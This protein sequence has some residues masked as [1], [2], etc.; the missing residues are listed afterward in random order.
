[1]ESSRLIG[2]MS[3]AVANNVC[4]DLKA[5][6]QAGFVPGPVAINLPEALLID[7]SGFEMLASILRE[8]GLEW[9]DLTVEVTEDVFLNRYAEHMLASMMRFREQGVCIALDDFGTGFASLLHLRDFPFDELK[10]DRGFVADIGLDSRSEQIITTIIDLSRNLGKRC[11][12]EGIETEAQRKFL[13]EAGCTIGQGYLFAKP[14]PASD[15]SH[16]WLKQHTASPGHGARLVDSKSD[17]T[18]RDH[19]HGSPGG[20]SWQ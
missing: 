17:W 3:R 1:M 11:V 6:K 13:L 7:E 14:M 18:S 12:A 9:Q 10:I 2:D 4:R 20:N 15:V 5:W 16:R 8:C 19:S